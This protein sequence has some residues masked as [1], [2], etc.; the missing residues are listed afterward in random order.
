[1]KKSACIFLLLLFLV[2]TAQLRAQGSLRSIRHI[3]YGQSDFQP[4]PIQHEM[5]EMEMRA[6]MKQDIAAMEVREIE[7]QD[8]VTI[9][10]EIQ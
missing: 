2:G 5:M 8:R 3:V 10:W 7:L 4:M 1:M 9:F 6:D